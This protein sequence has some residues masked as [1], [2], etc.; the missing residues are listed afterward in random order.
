MS[1]LDRADAVARKIE[2]F[3]AGSGPSDPLYISNRTLGQKVKLGLLIGIPVLAIGGIVALALSNYF[4]PAASEQKAAAV[5]AKPGSVTAKILPDLA[6]NYR[7]DNDTDCEVTEAMVSN[8]ALVG[9][10][11]NNTGRTV[12]L[13]DIIFDVTNVDGSQLG[14]VS[15]RVENIAPHATVDFRL[16]LEQKTARNALVREVHTR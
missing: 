5:A 16:P 13:A 14:A 15:V 12:N 2:R 1:F 7:S 4:N 9:K 8:N 11:R 3:V 10:L 6:K